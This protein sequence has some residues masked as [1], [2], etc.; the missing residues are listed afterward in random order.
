MKELPNV[1]IVGENSRGIYS[2][3]YGFELPNKWL[4]SLSH[5][6]YYNAAMVCNEGSGTPVDIVVKNTRED[7][8][9]MSDPVLVKAIH[10]A[11]KK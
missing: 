6:R 5:Q 8:V 1:T 10:L 11:V 3:M 7:L 2:D 4:V 9:T